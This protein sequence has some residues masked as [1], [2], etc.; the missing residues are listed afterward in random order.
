MEPTVW[1]E[2]YMKHLCPSTSSLPLLGSAYCQ[3]YTSIVK[4]SSHLGHS[5]GGA[6]CLLMNHTE[7]SSHVIVDDFHR[8][9]NA[10]L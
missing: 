5:W 2:K 9:C 4:V 3:H 8:K 7:I 10:H 6:L 1:K